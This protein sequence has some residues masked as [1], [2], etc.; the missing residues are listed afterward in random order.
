MLIQFLVRDEP[1]LGGWQSGLFTAGGTAKPALHAFALPLA[2]VSRRGGV[3]A[4]WGQVR[5]GSGARS[6]VLQ[7]YAG[8]KWSPV[9][10]TARTD[11]SGTLSRT[12][13]LPRGAR[14][15]IWSADAGYASPAL[16]VS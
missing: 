6:Y 4:L 10:G 9:G 16:T 15:R 12:A 5:P 7:R 13:T 3:V 11:A 2:Q 8:G 1:S 14:V